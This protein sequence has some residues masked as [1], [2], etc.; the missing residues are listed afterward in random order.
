MLTQ[1]EDHKFYHIGF[2]KI[3]ANFV[4]LFIIIFF[5]YYCYFILFYFYLKE[6]LSLSPIDHY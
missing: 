6:F 2:T 5:C 3:I 4:V 1:L